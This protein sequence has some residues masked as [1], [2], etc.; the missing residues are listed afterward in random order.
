M[1]LARDGEAEAALRVASDTKVICGSRRGRFGSHGW[2][3]AI[4]A[5]IGARSPA[6]EMN[7]GWYVGRPVMVTRNDYATGVFNGDTG[8]VVERDGRT[9]VALADGPNVRTVP[10]ARLESLSSWWSTTIHKSQGS[11]F[12]HAVV[13]LP[14]VDSPILTNELLYTGV[15][16]GR[17]RVSL[18]GSIDAITAAVRRRI[19]RASGLGARLWPNP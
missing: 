12:S 5:A 16:R 8:V 3:D 19:S 6:Q 11:E 1:S 7:R 4:E 9:L 13:S 17:D 10:L 14:E 2:G 18:V 15:T